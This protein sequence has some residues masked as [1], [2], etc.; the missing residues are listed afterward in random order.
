[1]Q[2]QNTYG[3][4]ESERLLKF[5]NGL[6]IYHEFICIAIVACAV[7]KHILTHPSLKMLKVFNCIFFFFFFFAT[8]TKPQMILVRTLSFFLA[9]KKAERKSGKLHQCCPNVFN[10]IRSEEE[11]SMHF[12]KN[13]SRITLKV[14]LVRSEKIIPKGYTLHS[15]R[16]TTHA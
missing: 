2:P 7:S 10:H 6:G 16:S 12:G 9:K 4:N 3:V 11:E 14:T 5:K 1:M 8:P 13:Q 15:G